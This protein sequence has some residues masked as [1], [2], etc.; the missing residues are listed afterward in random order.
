MKAS[1]NYT[2]Y[3]LAGGKSHI[4]SFTLKRY[5]SKIE[6]F[7]R[8]NRTH[9]LNPKYIENVEHFMGKSYVILSTGEKIQVSRRK[10]KTLLTL[11]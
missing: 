2:E 11:K 4:S 9:L 8:I 1:I 6:A 7:V 10:Q 5:E 3:F